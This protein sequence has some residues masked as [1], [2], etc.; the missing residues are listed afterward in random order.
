MKYTILTV[1]LQDWEMLV[2]HLKART[3]IEAWSVK[4]AEV[5]T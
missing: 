2:S 5:N 1:V 4:G 3:Q